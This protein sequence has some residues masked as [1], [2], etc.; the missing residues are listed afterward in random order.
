MSSAFFGRIVRA[1]GASQSLTFVVAA[2]DPGECIEIV[3][4]HA[5][6]GYE[7]EVVGRASPE[8]LG[9]LQLGPKEC[10]QMSS[11]PRKE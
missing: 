4:A 8:L 1:Q 9:S 5:P 6:I 10:K 11:T 2:Q 7:L 3:R